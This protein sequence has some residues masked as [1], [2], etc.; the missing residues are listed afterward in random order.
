MKRSRYW[1]LF[2]NPETPRATAGEPPRSPAVCKKPE[3]QPIAPGCR[4]GFLRHDLPVVIGLRG[5]RLML[6]H[7]LDDHFTN[8]F[9]RSVNY[10]R[11]LIHCVATAA[12]DAVVVGCKSK[13][14]GVRQRLTLELQILNS[15]A[16]GFGDIEHISH[17][18]GDVKV[19]GGNFFVHQFSWRLSGLV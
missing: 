15:L 2:V 14:L 19:V 5:D 4:S 3:R 17:P 12:V 7:P 11:V 8:L 16:K 18:L 9:T 13:V 6:L 10:R 1:R